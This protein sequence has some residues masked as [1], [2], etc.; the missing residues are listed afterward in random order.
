G[1]LVD[2]VQVDVQHIG[3]VLRATYDVR[4]PDLLGEGAPHPVLLRSVPSAPRGCP[5]RNLHL[6]I[7]DG[8]INP[9]TTIAHPV[10][11]RP[12]ASACW[13]RPPR[14]S[15]RWRPGR[16]RLPRWWQRPGL[17]VP[18]RTGSPSRWNTTVCSHATCRAGSCSDRVWVSSP[19]RRVRIV[20]WPPL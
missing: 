12:A 5:R 19:P 4:V 7:R 18:P 10:R 15:T 11:S 6:R 3:F 9:W 1:H 8:N 16:P 20:C 13:T 14:S 2:Q 17:R